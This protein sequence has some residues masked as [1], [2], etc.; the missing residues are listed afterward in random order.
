MSD[1]GK[2]I[3]TEVMVGNEGGIAN[4]DNRYRVS[5]GD[6]ENVLELASGNCCTI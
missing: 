2:S 1:I 6:D 3:E 4:D 5:F